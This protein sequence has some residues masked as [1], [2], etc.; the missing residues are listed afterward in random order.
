MKKVLLVGIFCLGLIQATQAQGAVKF[1]LTGGLLNADANIDLSLGNIIEIASID[2]VNETGFYIGALVDIEVAESFHVQPELTYGSA[3]DLSF[4]YVP[5][6][7]KYY[8]LANKLHIQAGP[9]FT[10][11]SNLDDIKNAIQDI[12]GVLGT[13][14][15]LDDVLNTFGVDLG[16]GAGFDVSDKFM[17]QARYAFELTDRYSGPL[18]SSLDIRGGTLNIGL[19]YFFN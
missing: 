5:I 8:V 11:S 3:G 7:A 4:V 13:N 18:G 15:N 2:A 16:F 1:G 9:Q 17:V 12:E 6:M 10:F 19:A 14:S